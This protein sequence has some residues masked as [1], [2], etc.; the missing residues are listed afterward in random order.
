[1]FFLII[2]AYAVF[3]ADEFDSKKNPA[4]ASSAA[5]EWSTTYV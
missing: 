5:C 4:L 3:Q 2:L 1:V